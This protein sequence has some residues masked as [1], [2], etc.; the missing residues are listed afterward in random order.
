MRQLFHKLYTVKLWT[1]WG[2]SILRQTIEDLQ[3]GEVTQMLT[4]AKLTLHEAT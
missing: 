2:A 3:A 4:H 1:W